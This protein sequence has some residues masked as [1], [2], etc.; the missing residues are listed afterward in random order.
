MTYRNIIFKKRF[1]RL[2][3]YYCLDKQISDGLSREFPLAKC[4]FTNHTVTSTF[5]AVVV[6]HK[7]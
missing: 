1:P 2:D 5:H 6:R 4:A 7:F 3:V